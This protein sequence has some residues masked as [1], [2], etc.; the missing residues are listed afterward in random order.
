[1]ITDAARPD[2]LIRQAFV[3]VKRVVRGR[4]ELPTF[5]F[6][7]ELPD[8]RESTEVRLSRPDDSSGHLGVHR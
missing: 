7:G 8:L 4:I 5:R 1:M 6:S 2:R 3:L